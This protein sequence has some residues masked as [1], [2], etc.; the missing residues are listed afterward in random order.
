MNTYKPINS[1]STGKNKQAG[2]FFE[3]LKEQAKAASFGLADSAYGQVAGKQRQTE[4]PQ[5]PFN[6]EKF[7]KMRESQVRG[8]ERSAARQRIITETIV[9]SRKE[10]AAQRQIEVIKQEIKTLV[11]QTGSLS[12]ELIEAQKAVSGNIPD[13][14]TGAYY[15]S[16]FDRIRKLIV[17]ARK[18]ITESRTWLTEFS[19]RRSSKNSYWGQFK[20][21]GAQFS[22]HH[23]RSVATQTG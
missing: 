10:D 15:V 18:R 6:F 13:V 3:A 17:L 22:L 8:Q 19:S 1:T 21:S 16:F 5:K 9:F 20:K 23:D 7:L 2:G 4:T 12:S 14:K 11:V